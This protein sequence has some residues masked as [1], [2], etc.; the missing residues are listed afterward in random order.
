M[1]KDGSPTFSK[2]TPL[3]FVSHLDRCT[4][5]MNP[6]LKHSIAVVI[7][8][9]VAGPLFALDGVGRELVAGRI[10]WISGSILISTL[11]ALFLSVV[12]FSPVATT[13]IYLIQNRLNLKWFFEP[14]VLLGI[15]AV[16]TIPIG[17]LLFGANFQLSL[18]ATF[19]FFFPTLLYFGILRALIFRELI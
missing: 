10:P 4:K 5:I 17:W 9:M 14:I 2:S 16:V 1:V 3:R 11:W 8:T 7:T 19:S 13:T 12:I 18:M 15:L 6:I